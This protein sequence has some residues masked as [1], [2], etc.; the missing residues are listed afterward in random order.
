MTATT[1]SAMSVSEPTLFVAFELSKKAWKLAMTAGFG[2]EPWLRTVL[3]GDLCAVKRV[4]GGA[5][6]FRLAED[7][8]VISCYEA[9]R[10]GFWIHRAADA[11]GSRIAWW[12]R[13]ASK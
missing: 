12:I 8:R 9:G 7:A 5:P 3:S 1:G 2:V 6:T 11:L 13:P 4:M 10:D